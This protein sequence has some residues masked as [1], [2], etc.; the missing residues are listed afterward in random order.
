MFSK[1]RLRS[2]D[3]KPFRRFETNPAFDVLKSRFSQTFGIN[4]FVP[5][6]TRR[7]TPNSSDKYSVL[8]MV[9]KEAF[10][11]NV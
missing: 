4:P 8:G 5:F 6:D 11:N 2:E 3:V 9:F 1:K 7:D 10:I